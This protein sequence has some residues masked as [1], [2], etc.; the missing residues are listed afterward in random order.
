MKSFDWAALQPVASVMPRGVL[1]LKVYTSL[2]KYH[3]GM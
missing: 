1:M 3:S 2:K